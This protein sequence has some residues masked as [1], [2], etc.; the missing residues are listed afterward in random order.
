MDD[1]YFAKIHALLAA[2]AGSGVSEIEVTEPTLRIRIVMAQAPLQVPAPMTAQ[3]VAQ[4]PV[5]KA[6][7]AAPISSTNETIVAPSYGQFHRAPSPDAPPFIEVGRRVSRGQELC[8][9]EAMKVFTTIRSPIDG[10]V[11]EILVETGTDVS[12]G[13]ALIR[14]EQ[15]VAETV[16]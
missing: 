5:D 15:L 9:M 11:S 12:P 14:I 1:A 3:P 16:Q 7:P 6:E 4:Q 10:I 13:Q 2:V 8:I